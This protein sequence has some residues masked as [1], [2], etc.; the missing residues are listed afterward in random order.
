MTK[1]S[2]ATL[3][4]MLINIFVSSLV[5]IWKWKRS[6]PSIALT[7]VRVIYLG[8]ISTSWS[9]ECNKWK[10]VPPYNILEIHCKQRNNHCSWNW[11]RKTLDDSSSNDK[12]ILQP[13]VPNKI[14]KTNTRTSSNP[15]VSCSGP[16]EDNANDDSTINTEVTKITEDVETNVTKAMAAITDPENADIFMRKKSLQLFSL[17]SKQRFPP[18]SNV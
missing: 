7:T 6:Y 9:N 12:T 5:Q 1:F 16:I 15:N 4:L 14:P 3:M 18:Y 10:N 8:K 13:A 11:L 2:A 17:F